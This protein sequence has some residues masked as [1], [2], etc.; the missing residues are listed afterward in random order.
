MKKLYR[1]L[2][3][4]IKGKPVVNYQGFNCGCCGEWIYENYSIP[5]YQSCGEWGDTWGLCD[6]CK[7]YGYEHKRI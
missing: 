1:Y 5:T 7:G 6:N 3:W 4:L 2:K